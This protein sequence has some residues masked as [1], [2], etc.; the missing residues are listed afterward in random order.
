[1]TK[2]GNTSGI[3]KII[4]LAVILI[5]PGFL[6]FLLERKGENRYQNLPVFGEKT[7]T[8]TFTSRMGKQVPD[9]LF[10]QISPFT[11]VN[12]QGEP[13]SVLGNDTTIAVV[14]F[15][16]TRCATFCK[17]MNDAMNSVADRFAANGMVNFYTITVDTAYDTPGVLQAYSEAY[18]PE[19]KK[20]HFL[21]GGRGTDDVYVIARNGFLVDAVRDTTREAHFIHSSSLILI[22]SKRRIR[23]YYDVNRNKEVDR[24]ID[25]VKLVLV[26][27]IREASPY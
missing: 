5:L 21:T 4:I 20:W 25:E 11:L 19:S 18:Q 17:H 23:G 8:G 16:Y 24:L 12:Q 22:D 14:N 6:Y 15:F 1:M 3:K 9:T 10:H 13:T 2:T 27:E 7:L 26:Q